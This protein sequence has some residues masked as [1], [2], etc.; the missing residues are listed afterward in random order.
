VNDDEQFA[1]DMESALEFL[2]KVRTHFKKRGYPQ[3]KLSD[4]DGVFRY[5]RFQHK[6]ITQGNAEW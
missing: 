6:K 3:S 5:V 4:I 1:H 2:K